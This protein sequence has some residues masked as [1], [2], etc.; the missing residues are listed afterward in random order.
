MHQLKCSVQ[1]YFW[2]KLGVSGAVGQ[3]VSATDDQPYAELWMGTHPNGPSYIGETKLVDYISSDPERILGPKWKELPFLFKIISVGKA[4]SIQAHPDR[5]L[6]QELHQKFPEIYRDSNHKPEMLIALTPFRALCSFRPVDEI[7]QNL[8]RVG[9]DSGKELREMLAKIMASSVSNISEL[10]DRLKRAETLNESDQLILDLDKDYP[11]DIGLLMVYFLNIVN[12][13][14]GEAI[15]IAPNEPH[16]Y[17]SGDGIECMACSDNVVRAGLTSKL[18][19]V[20]TLLKMLTYKT[21]RSEILKGELIQEGV[22]EYKGSSEEFRV[23]SI[24]NSGIIPLNGPA[25]LLFLTGA[26]VAIDLEI[27]NVKPSSCFF[28][29]SA[30]QIEIRMNSERLQVF[31]AT[32]NF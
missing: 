12:L 8:E 29:P 26:E 1:N 31:A 19:D 25:I 2:G 23:L 13:Q 5:I 28:V 20:P 21:G 18:K 6:A 4:L 17:L 27:F 24:E 32:T 14:P 11:N 10:V 9:L 15:F 30:K 3:F 22:L 16:S 7:V